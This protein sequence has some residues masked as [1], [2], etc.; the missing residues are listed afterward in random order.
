MSVAGGISTHDILI[1]QGYKLVDDAW[2]NNGRKT[3][4]HDNDAS[5]TQIANL[6]MTLGGA[7]WVRARNALWVFR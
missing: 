3:Y 2:H 5:G 1:Q 4:S 7:G 6:T